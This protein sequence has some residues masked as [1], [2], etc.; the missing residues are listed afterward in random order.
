MSQNDM[1]SETLPDD[2]VVTLREVTKENLDAVCELKVLPEQAN[3]V[4]DNAFSIAQAYFYSEAWFRAIY[5]ND[6]PVGFVMLSDNPI[7]GKYYLW[8]YMIDA[9]YQGRGYGKAAL[10]Q[11]IGYV[12]TRPNAT[13][14]TLSYVPGEHS[15]Q[16]FYQKLGFVDTGKED[17]GEL[18][19][20]LALE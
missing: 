12:R 16:P 13:E 9:R 2:A 4:A 8:R 1:P 11:V 6:T 7:E 18:E 17:H 15:P 14:M 5:A 19:M 10:E 3:N 20:R